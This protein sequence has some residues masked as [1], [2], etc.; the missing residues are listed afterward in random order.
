VNEHERHRDVLLPEV[1]GEEDEPSERGDDE[2]S[3][4]DSWQGGRSPGV[5]DVELFTNL[6]FV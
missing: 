3:Q 2:Q 1:R 4:G 6:N 5:Q